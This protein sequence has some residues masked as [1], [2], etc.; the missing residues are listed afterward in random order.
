VDAGRL[1]ATLR[2]SQAL[3]LLSAE[4]VARARATREQISRGRSRREVL[5][6]SAFARLQARMR[7]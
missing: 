4:V 1:D 3:T 5:H 6:E 7:T 2:E